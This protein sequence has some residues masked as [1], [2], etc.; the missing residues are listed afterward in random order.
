MRSKSSLAG[1]SIGLLFFLVA[2]IY[3]YD[4]GVGSIN[5]NSGVTAAECFDCLAQFGWPFRLHQSGTIMHVDEILW[6]GLSAD[7]FIAVF[8]SSVIG[9]LSFL[10]FNARNW[11]KDLEE[12]R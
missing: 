12:S 1:F 4:Y 10:L 7:I 6:T 8:L 5:G 9:A 2:N 11:R 3:S